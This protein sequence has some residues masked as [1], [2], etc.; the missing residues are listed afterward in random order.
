[1]CNILGVDK[2]ACG[3]EPEKRAEKNRASVVLLGLVFPSISL[4][5]LKGP[6]TGVE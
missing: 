4:D 5:S 1:M 2:A 3:C 6:L